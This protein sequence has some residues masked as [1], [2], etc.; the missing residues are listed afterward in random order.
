MKSRTEYIPR[1]SVR[2]VRRQIANYKR[3][4]SL[5]AEWIDLSI[6]QSRLAIKLA[7]RP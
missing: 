7:R 3:F 6:D 4:K 5:T 1:D 2:E